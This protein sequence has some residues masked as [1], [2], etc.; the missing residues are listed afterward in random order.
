MSS[1]R[2]V[3][4]AGGIGSGKTT[5]L[6]IL[7]ALGWSVISADAVGR[8]VLT[9]PVTVE[10]V[11][12]LWPEAVENGEVSRSALAAVVFGDLHKL[13]VLESIS[14]PQIIDRINQW[15]RSSRLPTAVEVSVPKV[16][17]PAWGS[18][19]VVHAP[20]ATRKQRAL[21]R[22]MAIA[23]LEARIAAQ[24]SDSDLLVRAD[25]VIDNQGSV[26]ALKKSVERFSVWL[27]NDEQT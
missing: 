8:E 21:E 16:V 22:G 17:Q 3:V 26:A 5:V 18:L 25:I 1:C 6:D 24:L 14:H 2:R 27:T 7:A 11:G 15:L 23:D 12:A 9:D 10:A 20:V 4:V 19:V 13:E